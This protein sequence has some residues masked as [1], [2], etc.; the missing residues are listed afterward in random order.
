MAVA[1]LGPT[2]CRK[3]RRTGFGLRSGPGLEKPADR[4]WVPVRARPTGQTRV[5]EMAPADSVSGWIFPID[6]AVQ[7]LIT[8]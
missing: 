6:S 3:N 4:V 8:Q 2:A 1:H 5:L 7:R